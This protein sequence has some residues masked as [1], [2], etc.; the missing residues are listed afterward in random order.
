MADSGK[1]MRSLMD[2]FVTT[3]YEVNVYTLAMVTA[4][5]EET[6]LSI[7]TKSKTKKIIRLSC[8]N[9]IQI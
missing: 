6:N 3:V 8:T 9:V 1:V 2:L 7:I 5:F 4:C